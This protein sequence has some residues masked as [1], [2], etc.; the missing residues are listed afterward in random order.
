MTGQNKIDEKLLA[1]LLD[2]LDD[3]GREEVELWLEESERNREYFREFQRI[4]LELQWGVYAREVKSDFNVMRKKL[5]KRSSLRIWYGS[6]DGDF[7]ECGR[8][9]FMGF[10]ESGGKIGT[11]GK[12]ENHSTG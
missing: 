11:G 7:T 9:A 3:V 8:D 5:R 10:G 1:Y 6:C 4:H 2:E 12:K